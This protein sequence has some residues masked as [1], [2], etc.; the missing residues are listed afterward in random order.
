MA[1]FKIIFFILFIISIKSKILKEVEPEP[2]SID[3]S[4]EIILYEN[5]SFNAYFVLEY[6][7]EELSNK[8]FLIITTKSEVFQNPAF[9][10]ASFTEKNP[11]SGNKTFCS[12]S[13]GKNEL[14]LNVSKLNNFNKLYINIHSLKECQL[15]FEVAIKNQILL[16]F[17]NKKTKFKLSDVNQI[18]FKPSQELSSKKLM[19]YS[20]GESSN[21][22]SMNIEYSHNNIKKEFKA[23]QKFENGY[24]IIIN[25]TEIEN[26]YLGNFQ[27]I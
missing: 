22:F 19:F 10:Y 4:K 25:L 12:Q 15:Q 1:N 18:V 20:I 3:Y 16:S 14:I 11:S 8:N 2:I 26:P 9:I 27:L 13:I 23:Q 6:T 7:K 21:Y 17:E 24:G 5:S